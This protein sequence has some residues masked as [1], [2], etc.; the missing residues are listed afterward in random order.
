MQ[1]PLQFIRSLIQTS[2]AIRCYVSTHSSPQAVCGSLRC[3]LVSCISVYTVIFQLMRLLLSL[4]FSLHSCS[5]LFV[6]QQQITQSFT[7]VYA[8]AYAQP[9]S[10]NSSASPYVLGFNAYIARPFGHSSYIEQ[11]QSDILTCTLFL[12]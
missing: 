2:T 6:V 5:F 12:G 8:L 10:S 11:T 9:R 7:K 3:Y 4:Y 1:F